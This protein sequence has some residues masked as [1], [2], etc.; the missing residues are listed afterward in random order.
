MNKMASIAMLIVPIKLEDSNQAVRSIEYSANTNVVNDILDTTRRTGA[1]PV[2]QIRDSGIAH[3]S[4]S[5]D[6]VP[7]VPGGW[8]GDKYAFD[9]TVSILTSDP[10]VKIIS[11]IQGYT[12]E[13]LIQGELP[14][15]EM[16]FNINSIIE[17][18]ETL[19]HGGPP[20]YAFKGAYSIAVSH[21]KESSMVSAS[22]IKHIM[23]P[24]NIG[25]HVQ[26]SNLASGGKSEFSSGLI[27][28]P[29]LV[30]TSNS[31][32]TAHILDVAQPINFRGVEVANSALG[33]GRDSEFYN[34]VSAPHIAI[35][36][37]EFLSCVG[38]AF[39][40]SPTTSIK[41]R[42]LDTLLASNGG[43][44]FSQ[45][46]TRLLSNTIQNNDLGI[47]NV[48]LTPM[49]DVSAIG[50]INAQ[51]IF[52]LK[53]IAN[54]FRLTQTVIR[55]T[56]PPETRV[57]GVTIHSYGSPIPQAVTPNILDY[58]ITSLIKDVTPL[59]NN[60]GVLS[61]D[62]LVNLE[63]NLASRVSTKINGHEEKVAEFATFASGSIDPQIGG[64]EANAG[65]VQTTSN[66]SVNVLQGIRG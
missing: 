30:S 18:S 31:S 28:I 26:M 11:F 19:N 16:T 44:L 51:I 10:N 52:T 9:I 50:K 35:S 43:G 41:A 6:H 42:D 38:M 36:D 56:F 62:S 58:I 27:R 48:G 33:H 53:G 7:I 15:P 24:A 55:L 54:S 49:A 29:Q 4:S 3:L 23:S 32:P 8:R 1:V 61:M 5:P 45:P 20:L 22:D 66:F 60:N 13:G 2:T 21:D 47:Y 34:G 57:L 14:D 46:T 25:T 59:L 37:S 17:I 65:L 12:S 39:N 63:W 64:T 40:G